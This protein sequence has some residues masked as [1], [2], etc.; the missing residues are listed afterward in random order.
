MAS[1]QTISIIIF[2]SDFGRVHYALSTAAAALATNISVTLMFTMGAIRAVTTDA[3]GNPQWKKLTHDDEN[4]E[5]GV[6]DDI[7][8]S[9]GIAGFEE[10][11][12]A[13]SSMGAKLLVCEMGLK[14]IGMEKKQLRKDMSFTPGGLVTFLNS[15][16][17]KGNIVFI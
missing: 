14:A 8:Q 5:G 15:A 9:R 6:Q 17:T 7:N 1:P 16:D 11:L 10:L 13:C 12:Q 3:S 4:T 2:S